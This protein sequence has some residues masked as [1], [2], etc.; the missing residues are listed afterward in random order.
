MT[1][2]DIILQKRVGREIHY[3]ANLPFILQ[4]LENLVIQLEK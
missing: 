1:L 2:R 3:V 4:G